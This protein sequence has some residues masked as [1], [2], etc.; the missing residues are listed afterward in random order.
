MQVASAAL[1]HTGVE[2]TKCYFCGKNGH[3]QANCRKY[4]Q[5]QKRAREETSGSES[6]LDDK[7][8]KKKKKKRSAARALTAIAPEGDPSVLLGDF[9][10]YSE[11][12]A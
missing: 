6:S 1:A 7:Q 4:K 8:S 9:D 5:A 11:I 12:S 2:K 10:D 3:R